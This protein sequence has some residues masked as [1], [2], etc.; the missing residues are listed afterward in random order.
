ME[1]VGEEGTA[2]EDIEIYFKS[3][4]YDICYLQQNAFDKEDA[5]C[6]LERQ[7]E[8]FNLINEIFEKK[9]SFDNHD[10]A[11]SFFLNM[12]NDL[13]NLNFLPY[14]TGEY[15]SLYEKIKKSIGQ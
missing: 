15:N 7:L 4:L 6:P 11:R 2:I 12:Q 8:T 14:R 10:A 3:E 1:V 9:F 5:Y 13:K